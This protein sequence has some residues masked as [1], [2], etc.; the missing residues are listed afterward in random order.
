MCR[1]AKERT[2]VGYNLRSGIYGIKNS[3]L[4]LC[5]EIYSQFEEAVYTKITELVIIYRN[6]CYNMHITKCFKHIHTKFHA[7]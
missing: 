3:S 1:G 6:V 4:N 2:Y 5:Y 7:E